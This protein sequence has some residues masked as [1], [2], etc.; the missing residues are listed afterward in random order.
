MLSHTN[1]IGAALAD[2][3]Q[4]KLNDDEAMLLMPAALLLHKHALASK[5]HPFDG[6]FSAQCLT[7]PAPDAIISFISVALMVQEEL[8]EVM[9]N[10]INV[11]K[12][13]PYSHN[14]YITL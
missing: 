9:M 3:I 10:Y 5:Q 2:K 4:A 6:K 12:I 13:Q 7:E 14:L 1:A 8:K 11:L